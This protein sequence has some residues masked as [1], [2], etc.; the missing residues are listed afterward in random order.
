MFDIFGYVCRAC[1][2]LLV[3]LLVAACGGLSGEPAIVATIPPPT[4]LPSDAGFP[5]TP[6]DLALGAQIFAQNCTQCHGVGGAGDGTLYTSGQIGFPGNFTEPD[7]ARGQTPEQW[8]QTI[9]NGRLENLMPPWRA[10]LTE[11]ER[12]AVALYTYTLHYRQADLTSGAA[13]WER[14]CVECHGAT[15]LGD[16]ERAAEV[17]RPGNLADPVEMVFASD[18]DYYDIITTG[19]DDLMPAYA[20]SLSEQERWAVTA[21]TRT[22]AL[23]STADAASQPQPP[24]STAE[25][26][27]VAAAENA[28]GVISGVVTNGTPGG[29]LPPD[30]TV[31]L[32]L[33]EQTAAGLQDETFETVINA[34][35]SFSFADIALDANYRYVV[36]VL[37]RDRIF[38]SDII[39]GDRI[40]ESP[41]IPLTIY[42]LTEDPT[43]ISI[44][45]V[46]MQIDAIGDGLQVLQEMT[47]R[48]NSDRLYTNSLPVGETRFVSVLAS[49][50]PGAVGVAFPGDPARF[51]Y[52]EEQSTVVDTIPVAPGE[53]H[54]VLFSYFLPYSD[55]AVIEQ[56]MF[57]ALDGQVN[58][59][60]Y[61]DTLALTSEQLTAGETQMIQ[62][63][64]YQV[65]S[66][67][68]AIDAGDV[69]RYE[70]SGA[71]RTVATAAES[72]AAASNLTVILIIVLLSL[73]VVAGV[74]LYIFLKR[75]VQPPAPAVNQ[76]MLLDGLIA[77]IAELDSQFEAGKIGEADYQSQRDQLKMRLSQLMKGSQPGA[78][79]A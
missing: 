15:G 52:V 33:I 54:T 71:A 63:R 46:E 79:R 11:E 44:A 29:E 74:V 34:D 13:I 9:T 75:G 47:Y 20:D 1:A 24:A 17:G 3:A 60:L 51:L 55:G 77:Q 5:E 30:L 72:V 69:L 31:T 64:T 4:P 61:P 62:D 45:G 16:G 25:A 7:A 40:I 8:F 2:L 78:D 26:E 53:D 70:L 67:D 41:E 39:P 68:V 35:G 38:A 42:E 14:E 43:V 36:S 73:V 58:L 49:L 18:A 66:G 48:N 23:R 27:A 12:W 37:Y 32:Y 28:N 22:L 59:R 6:P 65:F 76:Q 10:A 50:P 56:Q 57:Y 19:A 21:F